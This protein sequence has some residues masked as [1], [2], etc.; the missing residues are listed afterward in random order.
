MRYDVILLYYS[1]RFSRVQHGEIAT[2]FS[3]RAFTINYIAFKLW[4]ARVRR[5]VRRATVVRIRPVGRTNGTVKKENKI[6]N[7]A[8]YYYAFPA[9]I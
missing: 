6:Q 3:C 4:P 2:V 9:D 8:N 1:T 5:T 7:S